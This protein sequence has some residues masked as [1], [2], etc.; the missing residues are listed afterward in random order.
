MKAIWT[1]MD[2][3][4]HFRPIETGYSQEQPFCLASGNIIPSRGLK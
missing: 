1:E 4:H 3:N 2:S